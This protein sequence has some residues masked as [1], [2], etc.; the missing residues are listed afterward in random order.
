VNTTLTVDT[1]RMHY[2]NLTLLAPFHFRPRDVRRASELLCA[3]SLGAGRIIN[4]RRSLNE[5][6]EVFAML[7]RGTVL[8]CAVIP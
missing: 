1:R 7:E 6:G 4:A 3:G 5:L 2:D 8:K